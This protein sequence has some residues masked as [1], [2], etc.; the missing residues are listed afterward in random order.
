MPV[1]APPRQLLLSGF[2]PLI[3]TFIVRVIFTLRNVL[4]AMPT[5]WFRTFEE[6]VREGGDPES[7][8]LFALA[9]DLDVPRGSVARVLE[10]ARAVGLVAVDERTHVH[11]QLFPAGAL[12][13]AG[14]IF[15]E[16]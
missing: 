8:H 3:L 13:R 7:Q 16:A 15:P 12:G 14:V 11:L 2:Q 1:Q 6:N 4:G 9:V 5:S 10:V